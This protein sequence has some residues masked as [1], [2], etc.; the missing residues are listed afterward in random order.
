MP[1]ETTIS[2]DAL[3]M[4]YAPGLGR[5]A[6]HHA[7]DGDEAQDLLQD[8]AFALWRSLPSFRGDCSLRTW[9]YR[10][11]HNRAASHVARRRAPGV[12]LDVAAQVADPGA[13]PDEQ[14]QSSD[15]SARLRRAVAQLPH[16][17]QQ[18]VLLRL[19]GLSAREI[20]EVVGTSE[21]NVNVR[22]AR[23]RQI[24]RDLLGDDR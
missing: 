18:A 2:F 22:L 14:T 8:I 13:T 12:A 5:L 20:A 17:L 15:R 24:L 4:E 6:R 23:A 1:D 10:V 11:A 7:H 9:V 19:E 16:D 3:L 21:G